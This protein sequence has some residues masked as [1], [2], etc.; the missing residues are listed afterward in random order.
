M[1]NIKIQVFG[2]EIFFKLIT[3]LDLFKSV[4]YEKKIDF[5]DKQSL[6]IIFVDNIPDHLANK[7]FG[8]SLP[9]IAISQTSDNFKKKIRLNNYSVFLKTP[10]E[11]QAFCE[12]TKILLSKFS[13]FYNSRIKINSY[14]LNSN[15][16][17]IERNNKTLK[18][19]EIE[20]SLLI[21]LNNNNGSLKEDILI[22]VWKQHQPL[23]SHAFETC[24]HRL[25][26]K[27]FEKFNDEYFIKQ[28]NQKYFL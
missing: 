13:F 6:I 7:L 24:L 12:I 10:L 19:T 15:Q 20:V 28:K 27:V 16:K 14:Y 22:N 1:E 8:L 23:E 2:S 11:I 3:E 5:E 21:F 25:R 26:K 9:V 18:L 17:I 4:T